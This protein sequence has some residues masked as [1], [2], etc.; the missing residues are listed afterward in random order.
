MVTRDGIGVTIIGH[1]SEN[2]TKVQGFEEPGSYSRDIA[3]QTSVTQLEALAL[4]SNQCEQFVKY[5]CKSAVIYSHLTLKRYFWWVSRKG[6]TKYSWG[7]AP[8]DSDMCGCAVS[9]DGCSTATVRCNNCVL[10]SGIK[11]NC[12]VNDNVWREDSGLLVGKEHLPVMQLRTGDT[13]GS[14]E[15][16]YYTL[17]KLNCY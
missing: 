8:I 7:G 17:G 4:Q 11:C 16:A 10:T 15:E 9:D 2:R 1:D 14:G 6:D 13:G 3:Y 12:D 5:E